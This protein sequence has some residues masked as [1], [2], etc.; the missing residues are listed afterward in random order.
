M[1]DKEITAKIQSQLKSKYSDEGWVILFEVANATGNSITN[2]ADAILMGIYPSRGF[3]LHGFEIKA[4]RSDWLKELDNPSKAESIAKYMDYWWVVS[5]PKVVKEN[6]LP[7]DWGLMTSFEDQLKIKK[8]PNRLEPISLDRAIVASMLRN[9]KRGNPN[10]N[11]L[12]ES[13][14]K[15]Y[16]E[17]K[18][19]E[20]NNTNRLKEEL[21]SLKDKLSSFAEIT[22]IDL[23]NPYANLDI[24]KAEAFR[25]HMENKA[26]FDRF[27]KWDLDRLQRV[28]L[29]VVEEIQR[30]KN[31]PS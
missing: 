5:P 15:G 30:L 22:G 1:S 19:L 4:S 6:E 24:S 23:S 26:K 18:K 3:D 14:S 9:A 13:Y 20:G 7:F 31:L 8:R 12:K 27:E 25:N 11:L 10:E 21:N 16:Q 2:W 29:N 28:T 17:G